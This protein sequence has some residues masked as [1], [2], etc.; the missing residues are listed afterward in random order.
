VASG[1]PLG[2]VRSRIRWT[3]GHVQAPRLRVA[4]FITVIRLGW[5]TFLETVTL[6]AQDDASM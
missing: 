1:V 4:S 5:G 3:K 6:A 2:R